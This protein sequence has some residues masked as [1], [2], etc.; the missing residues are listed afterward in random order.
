MSDLLPHELPRGAC[1]C[2]D[3]ACARPTRNAARPATGLA[4]LAPVFACA[5]CPACLSL[6]AKAASVVGAG[7]AI[8]ETAHTVLL[9]V[10]MLVSIVAST[11]RYRAT[12]RLWPLGLSWV[13]VGLMT[14]AHVLGEV[15]SLELVGMG[16]LLG[17]VVVDRFALETRLKRLVQPS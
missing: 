13:G 1:G 17:S 16:A 2:G 3:V 14:L 7:L 15:T 5:F 4:A 12:R 10:A 11:Y 9:V 6:Y 8:S